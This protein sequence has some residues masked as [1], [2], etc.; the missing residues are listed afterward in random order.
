MFVLLHFEVSEHKLTNSRINIITNRFKLTIKHLYIYYLVW[1]IRFI[2]GVVHKTVKMFMLCNIIHNLNLVYIL[3]ISTIF[4]VGIPLFCILSRYCLLSC[5][6]VYYIL[7]FR[8]IRLKNVSK[9][10]QKISQY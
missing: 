6:F 4:S 3:G 1:N 7:N 9:F 8:F 5:P 2:C 10:N